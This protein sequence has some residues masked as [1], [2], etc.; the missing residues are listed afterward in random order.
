MRPRTTVSALR[1]TRFSSPGASNS[2]PA[3]VAAAM[4]AATGASAAPSTAL[5]LVGSCSR[6]AL[7][8]FRRAAAAPHAAPASAPAAATAAAAGPLIIR[9]PRGSAT[10][11][12]CTWRDAGGPLPAQSP[13]SSPMHRSG[14]PSFLIVC[15][16]IHSMCNCVIKPQFPQNRFSQR[17]ADRKSAR[18]GLGDAR[19]LVRVARP[20]GSPGT[21]P[22]S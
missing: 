1:S 6:A 16:V 21:S 14:V 7:P 13:A 10:G 15:T 18:D 17:A 12:T 19:G 20:R 4:A 9:S 8:G 3:A 22:R 5:L 11:A 2:P